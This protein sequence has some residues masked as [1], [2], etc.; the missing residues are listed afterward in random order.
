MHSK[1]LIE[2]RVFEDYQTEN[3]SWGGSKN[4]ERHE[5]SRH[6]QCSVAMLG[7]HSI[8]AKGHDRGQNERKQSQVRAQTGTD[9]HVLS[10]QVL[11]RK[12]RPTSM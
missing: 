12:E 5:Q 8:Q 7:N 11:F 1:Q 6:I 3:S 4:G 10:T 2:V 9:R